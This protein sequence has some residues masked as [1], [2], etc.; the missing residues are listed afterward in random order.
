[1]RYPKIPPVEKSQLRAA[2]VDAHSHT[3][4]MLGVVEANSTEV[5]PPRPDCDPLL[6]NLGHIAWFQE[7]FGLRSEQPSQI[8][9][10]TSLFDPAITGRRARW[11]ADLPDGAR[12]LAWKSE[13][14]DRL[15]DSIAGDGPAS[16]ED[17]YFIRLAIQIEDMRG[18][19]L[20]RARQALGQPS[21]DLGPH[22]NVPAGEAATGD[23]SIPA[24]IHMQ[25][26][27]SRDPF[28]MDNEKWG[29]GYEVKPF[30]IA[31]MPV[32]NAEYRDFVEDE[33]YQREEL[34]S[35]VGWGWR[36][37]EA[38]QHPRFWEKRDGV[39]VARGFDRVEPL[40][41]DTPV[42]HVTWYEAEAWC[43]WAHR[44]LPVGRGVGGRSSASPYTGPRDVAW[45]NAALSVG[46]DSADRPAG[47]YG[48][49]ARRDR[50]GLGISWRG[51]RLWLPPD[52]RQCLG[53]DGF[54]LRCL[55]RF[56]GGC[57]GGLFSIV[58]RWPPRRVARRFVGDPRPRRLEQF[59]RVSAARQGG[60]FCWFQDLCDLSRF[61]LRGLYRVPQPRR[62][63]RHRNIGYAKR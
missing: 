54:R 18:E 27:S 23:V 59:S 35:R 58:F 61:R 51:Q 33:G 2:L 43:R 24:G 37:H 32:T 42:I 13:I 17:S 36:R 6:W 52:G 47:E 30:A 4:A 29:H 57:L 34:W 38:A 28:Y 3:L 63:C 55:Y 45:D 49:P 50:A 26:A 15:I 8:E 25:G 39:W 56:R 12:L 7:K 16:V 48:W 20:M 22:G 14:C 44:R 53:M 21:P 40:I 46:R 60:C 41:E 1:M 11:E 10:A 62:R 9:N 19:A 31:R 5:L